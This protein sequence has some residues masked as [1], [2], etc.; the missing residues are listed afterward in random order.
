MT[1]GKFIEIIPPDL[2]SKE[3]KDEF[4]LWLAG[5]PVDV[6]TKKYVLMDWCTVVGVALTREMV[7]FVTGGREDAT[8]G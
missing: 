5:L 3:K 2:L 8:W 7:R 6:N 1:V 4:L